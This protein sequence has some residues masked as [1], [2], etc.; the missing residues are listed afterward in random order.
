VGGTQNTLDACRELGI[1]DL[2]Y[3]STAYVCGM[4]QGVIREDELACGQDFRN[5]YEH[6]KLLA[7]KMVR[8]ADFLEQ[9]TVYR[10]AVIAGD[11]QSGYTNT[12]HGLYMYLKLMSVLVWNEQPGPDGRR[13]TPVRLNMTGEERRNIVPVDWV[14][15]VICR[16]FD[17]PEAHGGTYHLAPQQP[18]TPR[19]IIAAGYKYFN[20]YGVEFCGTDRDLAGTAGPM[21]ETARSQGTIYQPY[22]TTD[23]FFDMTNTQKFAADLPCPKIDEPML[24]RFWRYGEEDR[25][26]KRR[27]PKATVSFWVRDQLQGTAA[28]PY[29]D[30]DPPGSERPETPLA[31]GLDISGPGGGQWQVLLRGDRLHDVERGVPVRAAAMLRVS[32]QNWQDLRHMPRG[33]ALRR[34]SDSLEILNGVPA[35]RVAGWVLGALFPPAVQPRES[36]THQL[37]IEADRLGKASSTLSE[38]STQ[39]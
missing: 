11:S 3:V 13:Y 25:W 26:G 19:E 8:E 36:P 34:L 30:L 10:P 32:T 27:E 17:T 1:R 20:S 15:A 21:D 2:H 38:A 28:R 35:T 6:S 9:V 18:L 37:R 4:R 29:N 7:E 12:Y 39:R 33:E 14:S 22:E 24:H 23:P 31:V 5:D 16:L